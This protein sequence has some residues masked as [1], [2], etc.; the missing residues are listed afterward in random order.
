MSESLRNDGRIWVPKD[1]GRQ[2]SA[3]TRSRRR[4][5]TTT[6]S[7]SIRASAT[8]PRATSPRAP[9]RRCATRGAASA[10]SGRGV[11]LDF[12]D[13]IKRLG[14][15][16]SSRSA[17]ATSS[18]CT[19]DITGEDPYEVPMRIYPAPH[20][21]MGG[22]W[23]DYNLMSTIPGL[24]VDRRGELLRPRRQ[25]PRRQRA[26]AGPGRRLLR[27]PVHDRRL[28]GRR[29]SARRCRPTIPRSREAEPTC[30]E[31]V[32]QAALDPR[33]RAASTRSTASSARSCGT[34]AAWPAPPRG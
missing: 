27:P 3:A 33:E 23:V 20:Y 19:S 1:A 2:A 34:T 8:S 12:A 10:P 7:A 32:D 9:R 16:R 25:P 6:S 22:L 11:Y 15:Q 31:R 30:G 18:R 17:T 21:T 28:P 26:D 5:A 29:S 4:S 13:A 24:Y 14:A